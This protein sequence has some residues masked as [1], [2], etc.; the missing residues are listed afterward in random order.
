MYRWY[1]RHLEARQ[2]IERA[3]QQA[4]SGRPVGMLRKHMPTRRDFLLALVVLGT[5]ALTGL[6]LQ[7]LG[8]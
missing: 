8:Y 3:E 7:L 1:G 6:A 4:R 5:L 2:R